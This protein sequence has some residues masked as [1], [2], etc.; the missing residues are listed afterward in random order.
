LIGFFSFNLVAA[1]FGLSPAGI[2]VQRIIYALVG[3]AG[4][5]GIWVVSRLSAARDDVC[6]PGHTPA[7][8]PH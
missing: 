1:I 7:V 5:Y 4:I 3:L 6:V 2:V 8:V